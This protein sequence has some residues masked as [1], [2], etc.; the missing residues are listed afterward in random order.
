[1]P[2]IFLIDDSIVAV[3]IPKSIFEPMGVV[4]HHIRTPEE[5]FGMRGQTAAV[6]KHGR[7]DVILLDIV[8][9][10]MDGIEVLRKLKNRSDTKDIPVV[11]L[12]ASTSEDN[13]HQ[14]LELG[15]VGY[16]KKPIDRLAMLNQV[17]NATKSNKNQELAEILEPYLN[18]D[19]MV[20]D[21]DENLKVGKVDLN[22]LYDLMD[23]DEDLLRELINAFVEDCPRQIH[24]ISTAIQSK[25]AEALRIAAHTFK[26]SVANFGA[27]L[28]TDKAMSIEELAKAGKPQE[29]SEIFDKLAAE[30]DLVHDA[31]SD[32]LRERFG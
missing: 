25:D 20:E 32:W 17:A 29:A 27:N 1:M 6:A 8:M 11:M 15:A 19:I 5:L 31:L 22:Y 2:S 28:I 12:T 26:G 13:V 30:V 14:A 9:P 16:L 3:K 7:P 18:V 10:E 21:G 24:A 4:L 23:G